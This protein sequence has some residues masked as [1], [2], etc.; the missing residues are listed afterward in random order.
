MDNWITVCIHFIAAS[1]GEVLNWS[2]EATQDWNSVIFAAVLSLHWQRDGVNMNT[3]CCAI[4][5]CK[6]RIVVIPCKFT[7]TLYMG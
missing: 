7:P 1:D 2:F 6:G 5:N 3:M 4:F